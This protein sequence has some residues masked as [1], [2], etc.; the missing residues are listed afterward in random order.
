MADGSQIEIA[1]SD[2]AEPQRRSHTGPARHPPSHPRIPLCAV[3]ASRTDRHR[4]A[5]RHQVPR[6]GR[7]SDGGPRRSA[8]RVCRGDPHQPLA[9]TAWDE[10]SRSGDG[11]NAR[12]GPLRAGDRVRAR[13]VQ[14]TPLV[15]QPHVFAAFEVGVLDASAGV[16]E[17][18]EWLEGAVDAEGD[19]EDGGEVLLVECGEEA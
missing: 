11:G 12:G 17:V 9:A 19:E 18:G 10:H 1:V 6:H 13:G 8:S 7:R 15:I 5:Y 3:G 4:P 2:R 16:G 14:S